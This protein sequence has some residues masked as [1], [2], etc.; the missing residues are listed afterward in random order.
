MTRPEGICGTA[1]GAGRDGIDRAPALFTDLYELTMLQAFLERGMTGEAVFS[2]FVRRLPAERNYLMAAGLETVL[3]YL[4]RVRFEPAD[5]DYL[6][7]LGLFGDTLLNW[8]VDFRFTGDVYALREGTPVF[9][10]EPIVEIVAPLTQAQV[11]ETFVTNQI[12]LQ[13]MLAS[14]ASRVVT[15][16]QGCRVVDFGARRMHG[17]DAAAKAARAFA[18]AGVQGT[19]NVEAARRY[20]LDPAGTMAHSYIQAFDDEMEAFRA[21]TALYPDTVLLVDTY[22]TLK[23]VEKVVALAQEQGDAFRVRALRLDS[24]D[25]AALTKAAR[26]KLD[27]AGLTGVGLFVSGGL[28]EYRVRDL[29][30]AGAPIDGFGV[31]TRMGTSADAPS[32]DIVYKL[33]EYEDAGRIKLATGK[34]LLPGRKQVFRREETDQAVGDV[35]ARDGED[36]DGRPLLEPVMRGGRR[37]ADAPPLADLARNAEVELAR[38]PDHIRAIGAAEP[39][40]E[41][42]VSDALAAYQADVVARVSAPDVTR[43]EAERVRPASRR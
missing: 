14:K 40:Y 27:A 17:L 42:R 6:A 13:T 9:A 10:E 20:G 29:L 5:I 19:S 2:V 32:L 37:L 7:T 26:T 8:L 21:F 12:Q 22:D 39:A 33:C 15:A 4:E 24:G 34:T 18:I 38:L 41:V 1:G 11:I 16:A 25:L 3:D 30:D 28:D 36:V 43:S 31:G 35:I 23:A